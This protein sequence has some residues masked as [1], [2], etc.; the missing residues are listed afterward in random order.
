MA[1]AQGIRKQLVYVKEASWGVAPPAATA[2]QTIRRVTGQFNLKKDTYQSEE[3]RTDYQMADF[4]HGIRSADGSLNGEFSPGTYAPFVSAALA[5]AFSAI[6]T[7]S[8]GSVTVAGTGPSY[9]ISR[10]T[11]SYLTDGI[12][13][14]HVV[15]FT[16]LNANN[17]NK[18]LL[19]T[20]LTGTLL[21]VV[22]L[23]GT[24]LTAETVATGGAY[25]VPGR[26]NYVPTTGH[27]D[28]SFT[29]ED[30]QADV[31][32]YERFVGLKVNSL[33]VSIPAN[34]LSTVDVAFMGKDMDR[35]ASTPYFTGTVN[36][37]GTT[38]IFAGVNGALILNGAVVGF[39][40]SVDFTVNRNLTM[41][42]VV[43][44][45]VNPDIFEGRCLVDGTF[46]AYFFDGVAPELFASETETSLVVALTT[47]NANNADFV[48][49]SLP[50][51]KVN[52]SDKD[53]GEKGI[54]RTYPFQALYN[55]A[56]GAAVKT[57][58]TT[59]QIQ[60]STVTTSI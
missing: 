12:K 24:T 28:D 7:T 8:P 55:F 13:I 17:N 29:F 41:E 23:N 18:N 6:T 20:D 15:R 27:T 38:G 53:D 25:T 56:G 21:T 36:A 14:G 43:G 37:E 40:T 30:R 44:S 32:Y 16:G 49:V 48:T 50:R 46:S 34:G 42:P 4:R 10:A 39:V 22:V 59:I 31:P 57:Q 58:A 3:I 47:S 9:T 60:D 11:G 52:G 1:I 2:V 19:V 35:G 33:A 26:E 51:I 5:R 54:I 45:N